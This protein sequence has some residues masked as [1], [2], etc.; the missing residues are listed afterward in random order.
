MSSIAKTGDVKFETVPT[1]SSVENSNELSVLT[2]SKTKK[3]VDS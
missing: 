3:H 1:V 2:V